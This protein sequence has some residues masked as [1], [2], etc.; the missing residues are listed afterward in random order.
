M[1]IQWIS[2]RSAAAVLLFAALVLPAF[3]QAS[4]VPLTGRQLVAGSPHV[5]VAVVEEARTRWNRQRTLLFT[6]YILSIEDR[7]R[8]EAPERVTISVPGGSLDGETHSTNLST[9]LEAGARYLLFLEDFDH[10]TLLPIT[11][12]WQG[13]I[14]ANVD[15][16]DLAAKIRGLIDL[17]E[18]SPEPADTA[19][20]ARGE[21]SDL[22]AKAWDP[23]AKFIIRDPA[24]AP[25][26]FNPLA[27]DNR[28]SPH[29]QKQMAYWNVYARDLFRVLPNPSPNWAFGND[30]SDIAGFPSSAQMQQQFDRAWSPGAV[31]LT[32][33]RFREGHIIECDIALNPAFQ[34]TLD[35]AASTV[36]QGPISFRDTILSNLGRAWGYRGQFD[37]LGGISLSPVTRDSVMNLK[38]PANSLATLL[39]EDTRAVRSIH[40][41]TSIRDGVISAYSTAPAPLTPFY[42]P[43]RSSASSVRAGGTFALLNPVKIENTGTED[44]ENPTVE[45]YLVPKRFSL[46]RSILVKKVNLQALLHSGDAQTFSLGVVTLPRN[47]RPGTYFFAFVL[48]D[49]RDGYQANNTAWSQFDVK[50]RVRA[51]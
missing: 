17:V 11:G 7:L 24:V 10:P 34:W 42:V 16:P 21:D 15:L 35:D 41:G 22:P 14:P 25:I 3:A 31:S 26:V 38:E 47:T 32:A 39:A 48:R 43:V 1:S 49:A 12:G 46:N 50:I 28:F 44:L 33:T 5:V 29:D 40:P 2:R 6:D 19:W 30:V 36:P 13:V 37:I 4:V 20:L 23:A 45:V 51:R 18:T 27:R 8:G 9:P